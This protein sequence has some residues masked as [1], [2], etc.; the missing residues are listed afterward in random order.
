MKMVTVTVAA[1]MLISCGKEETRTVKQ[2]NNTIVI[3]EDA[4]LL[5]G[6]C[7][8]NGGTVKYKVIGKSAEGVHLMQDHIFPCFRKFYFMPAH[9]VGELTRVSCVGGDT[10]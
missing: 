1:M 6:D 8:I 9:R 3:V 4:P 10:W 5:V 7:V 2:T